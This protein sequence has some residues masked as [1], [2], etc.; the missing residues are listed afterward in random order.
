MASSEKRDGVSSISDIARLAGVSASTVSRAL[1]GS[2][3]ISLETR[4]RINELA[5]EHGFQLNQMARNLRLKRTNAIGIVF[6]L[7]HDISQLVSDPFFVT[8]LGHVADGVTA[9]GY[10]LLL[11]RIV[12]GDDGWLDVLVNSGRVDGVIVI[13]RS[14]QDAVLRRVASGYRPIVVWGEQTAD[15]GYCSVGTDDVAGGAIATRHLL[16]GGRRGILYAGHSELPEI[17]ARYEGFLAAH[18]EAGIEPGGMVLAPLHSE[19]AYQ[20]FVEH[21]A[22]HPAPGGIVAASDL[23]AVAAIRALVGHGLSVPGQVAVVG[24]GDGPL[25][26][27]VA[28]S[29]STVRQNLR[30]GAEQLVDRLF[31]RLGGESCDPI[32]MT[33]ELILRASAP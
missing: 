24:Y 15:Q 10:D 14:N 5:R 19:G 22:D 17:H 7:G 25:A 23:I 9:R 2:K 29:L 21:L 33:P 31:R 11:T 13:G 1:A 26:S 28:P 4:T 32:V 8:M 27:Q 20:L 3:M 16:A 12:P 18:R 30:E 6:P